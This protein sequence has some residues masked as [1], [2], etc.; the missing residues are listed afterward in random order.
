MYSHRHYR[1][2]EHL[3]TSKRKLISISSHSP[4]F[5]LPSL[6][7]TLSYFVSMGCLFWTFHINGILQFMA[8]CVWFLSLK[9]NVFEVH[10]R[11]RMN[12]YF[13]LFSTVAKPVC[14]PASDVQVFQFF[15]ILAQT[16]FPFLKTVSILVGAKWFLICISLVTN[17]VEHLF[18]C[19]LAICMPLEK[20]LFKT[21]SRFSNSFFF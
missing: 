20:G 4:F 5:L 11:C 18:T 6:W 21:F 3:I 12:Q 15:H 7:Q 8:F 10:P 19:S 17:G 13:K 1:I 2:P 9:H 14:I 16:Y